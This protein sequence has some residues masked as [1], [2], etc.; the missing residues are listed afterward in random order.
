MLY[1][2]RVNLD[3]IIAI[4]GDGIIMESQLYEAKENYLENYKVANP[5]QP[6]PPEDF[7]AVS[8]THLTLPTISRV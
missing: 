1:S 3:K 6:L 7:I 5:T 8:Y 2:E 4:A